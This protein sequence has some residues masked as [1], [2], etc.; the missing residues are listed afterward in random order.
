MPSTFR[1]IP[2][3]NSNHVHRIAAGLADRTIIIG[4]NEISHY[5]ILTTSAPNLKLKQ[6]RVQDL[7]NSKDNS[8]VLE[9]KIK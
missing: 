4:Q 9:K 6:K 3:I 5:R 8:N 2:A 1:A 7:N